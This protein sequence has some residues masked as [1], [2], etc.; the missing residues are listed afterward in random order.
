[1]STSLIPVVI[2]ESLVLYILWR[3]FVRSAA[4]DKDAH[5]V[6]KLVLLCLGAVACTAAIAPL[7]GW[8]PTVGTVLAVAALAFMAQADPT[9]ALSRINDTIDDLFNV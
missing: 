3:V 9:S 2:H 7:Y 4:T 8:T 5:I 1:M 6:R